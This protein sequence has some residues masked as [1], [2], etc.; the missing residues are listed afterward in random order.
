MI[1][2]HCHTMLA[3]VPA[4]LSENP[5][6]WFVSLFVTGKARAVFSFLFGVSFAVMMHRLEARQQP[7]VRF[8]LR[9]LL[10]LYL[11]GFA[12]EIFTR[13]AIL[14]EYALWGVVLLFLRNH[15][16]RTLLAVAVLSAAAF[17]I[18]DL[19]D[20][21][22]SIVTR[23]LDVTVAEE[24]LR[25]NEW[26]ESHRRLDDLLAHPHYAEV[27]KIRLHN[28]LGDQFSL[29]GLTPDTYLAL[30]IL[31]LLSV[32]HGIFSA[33]RERRRW[34]LVAGA[35]GIMCW[36]VAHWLLPLVPEAWPTPRI[37]V[38][39]RSGLGLVNEQF[40]AL[41]WISAITLLLTWRPRWSTGLAPLGWIGRMALTNYILQAVAI[42]FAC[43]TYGLNLKLAPWEEL[44]ATVML[45]G[46][47]AGFSYYWLGRFRYGPLEWMWRTLTYGR[48]QPMALDQ[49]R[50]V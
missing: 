12:V 28:L 43:A 7:V 18:R 4:S 37:A 14:R 39:F 17:S 50:H 45:F 42:D 13:F 10:V 44:A 35:T 34:L 9:R 16:T 11:I 38:R 19:A 32:R 29:Q 3:T 22:Y 15:P 8:F 33:T 1:W 24:T 31:G 26:A 6:G 2:V 27:I 40:L 49:P 46:I 20:S 5:A 25:Q 21:G 30:F 23:G 48:L 47:L 36:A 41:T